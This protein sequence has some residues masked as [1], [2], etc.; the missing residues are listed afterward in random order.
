VSASADAA[1]GFVTRLGLT[2]GQVVQE[3]GWDD[4]VDDALRVA[5]EDAVD[6]DLLDEDAIEVADV[7][8]LWWRADDGDLVDALVDALTNL[9]ERGAVLLLTPKA[10]RAGQVQPSDVS[11]AALAAG[12]HGT[13]SVS[14]GPDWGATRL[15]A[16]RSARR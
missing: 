3:L 14:A 15:V 11:E 6:G 8:L 1:A 10:G 7:V 5:I 2:S 16:P 12:L 9:G 13:S 4:D